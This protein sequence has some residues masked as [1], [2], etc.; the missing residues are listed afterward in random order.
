MKFVV[1]Q[2]S[3]SENRMAGA[4]ENLVSNAL[5][6][7]HIELKIMAHP[8]ISKYVVLIAKVGNDSSWITSIT[9]YFRNE[10]FPEDENGIAKIKARAFRYALINDILYMR[11]AKPL[12]AGGHYA[13]AL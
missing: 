10:T 9:S 13:I 2:V 11:S 7:C 3:R 4:L 5:Y 8:S 12:L 6:L 1:A